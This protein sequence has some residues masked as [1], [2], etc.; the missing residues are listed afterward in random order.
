MERLLIIL[1]D[2]EGRRFKLNDAT[3]PSPNPDRQYLWRKTRPSSK[4][5]W[6]GTIE[7]MEKGLKEFKYY[8]RNPQKGAARCKVSFLHARKAGRMVH[9]GP[10]DMPVTQTRL[11]EIFE[12]CKTNLITRVDVLGFEFEMGLQPRI[13]QELREKGVHFRLRYI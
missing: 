3:L 12:E 8:L 10:L 1:L 6:P 2:E 4:K 9:I 13:I 7:E 11:Q 5:S